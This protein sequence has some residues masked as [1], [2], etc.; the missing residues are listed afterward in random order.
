MD[1]TW[2]YALLA[3]AAFAGI[4]VL[5]ASGPTSRLFI[6]G[7]GRLP[8]RFEVKDIANR[9]IPL[10]ARRPLE[11][12][13]RRLGLL[14]FVVAGSPARVPAFQTLG[15]RLLIVPFVHT[16]E[17]TFFLMGIEAGLH[18]RTQLMLHIITPL[19]EGRRVETSTLAPLDSLRQPDKV[20]AR[21]VLDAD[22]VEEIWSRHRRALCEYQR[23]ERDSVTAESWYLH[24]ASAYEG[25]VQ[26]AVRAQRLELVANGKMYRIRA[27]PKSPI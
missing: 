12:L 25:W 5:L 9:D 20:A 7:R 21:V 23:G 27:R 11:F 4:L 17:R 8:K 2:T 14:G 24:A 18:P 13:E 1:A 10:D 22:T 26:S 3:G 6:G 16:K 19:S 15:H